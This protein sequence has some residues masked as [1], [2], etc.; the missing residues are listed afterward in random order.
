[1]HH[2]EKYTSP[3]DLVEN[4]IHLAKALEEKASRDIA[5]SG[6][7]FSPQI[8]CAVVLSMVLLLL[9]IS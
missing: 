7:M 1:V 8:I 2:R 9:H 4:L 3:F 6:F 5:I